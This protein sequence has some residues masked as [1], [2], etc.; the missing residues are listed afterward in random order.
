MITTIENH[1]MH[2]HNEEFF[3]FKC[4]IWIDGIMVDPCTILPCEQAGRY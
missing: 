4:C 1:L 3:F 2:I